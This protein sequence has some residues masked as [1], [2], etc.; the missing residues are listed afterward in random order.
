LAYFSAH[1]IRGEE[2]EWEGVVKKYGGGNYAKFVKYLAISICLAMWTK[3]TMEKIF[4][5]YF[6][7]HDITDR[8]ALF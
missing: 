1:R 5:L 8:I 3:L 7:V 4:V 6:S 2:L